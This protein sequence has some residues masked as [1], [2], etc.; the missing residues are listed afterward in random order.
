MMMV[1]LGVVLFVITSVFCCSLVH[2]HEACHG[3]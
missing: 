3:W 1:S 2:R